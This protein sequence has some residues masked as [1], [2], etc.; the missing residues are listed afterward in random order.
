M[1][2][3]I[4]YLLLTVTCCSCT[5][6]Q[7][8]TALGIQ[9]AALDAADVAANAYEHQHAEAVIAAET[10]PKLQADIA[11]F[12]TTMDKVHADIDGGYRLAAAAGVANDDPTLK[13][14]ELAVAAVHA[15][16]VTIGVLPK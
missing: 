13:T 16:L 7:R 5:G 3:F 9:V 6:P 1:K 11:T 10:G 12:R 8:N 2:H 14:L 15:E 4:V